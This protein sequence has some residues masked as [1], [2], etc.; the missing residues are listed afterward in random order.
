MPLGW[1]HTYA[2]GDYCYARSLFRH[3]YNA[4]LEREKASNALATAIEEEE[5][6]DPVDDD[7]AYPTLIRGDA[8][9][10]HDRGFGGLALLHKFAFPVNS[11]IG[12]PTLSLA[13]VDPVT[14]L[15]AGSVFCDPTCTINATDA[16]DGSDWDP[17]LTREKVVAGFAGISLPGTG[18][19]IRRAPRQL[20][21]LAASTDL[22]GNTIVDGM[23]AY[24]RDVTV[25]ARRVYER[26][27]GAWVMQP[28][29]ARPDVLDSTNGD[30]PDITEYHP[31]L[32][33]DVTY[34]PDGIHAGD[35]WGV[36]LWQQMQDA[37]N[38]MGYLFY[39][40]DVTGVWAAEWG[41]PLWA[42]NHTIGETYGL[43][44]G[45]TII[46]DGSDDDY[47]D[48]L[49]TAQTRWDDNSYLD[50]AAPDAP[51]HF[52][53]VQAT[54]GPPD[55]YY[56]LLEGS[57]SEAAAFHHHR[58]RRAELKLYSYPR[59]I[60]EVL[61]HATVGGWDANGSGLTEDQWNL[62]AS[63]QEPE[64][65][66]P[67]DAIKT[68]YS[69]TF[70]GPEPPGEY[71]YTADP[72]ATDPTTYSAWGWYLPELGGASAVGSVNYLITGGFDYQA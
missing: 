45:D 35:Y 15:H 52:A 30:F 71:P 64:D 42:A 48:A 72:G 9:T 49:D 10:Y 6:I 65:R 21:S 51:F 70:L 5:A 59:S 37:Y 31:G 60:H 18:D 69:G 4:Y 58:H 12:E 16:L 26:V 57:R 68:S 22:H 28:Q 53:E 55:S 46:V 62:I 14:A 43:K 19:I 7:H 34:R 23:R 2:A 40:T 8:P 44:S 20:T 1:N 25:G 47:A 39:G 38:L 41:Y 17:W 13:P 66:D 36:H 32:E 33:R 27:A 24:Y 67:P 61:P 56:V 3:F 50:P 54:A 63:W 29:S 11:P